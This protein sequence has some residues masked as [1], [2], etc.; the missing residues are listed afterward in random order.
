VSV[1]FRTFVVAAGL[2]APLGGLWLTTIS[3][4]PQSSS[5]RDDDVVARLLVASFSLPGGGG[6][7]F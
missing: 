5:L 2:A 6:A 1:V 3:L 4:L 7:A